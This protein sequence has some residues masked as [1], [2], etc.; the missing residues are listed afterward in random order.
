MEFEVLRQ[1]L[2][3]AMKMERCEWKQGVHVFKPLLEKVS[4]DL[5]DILQRDSF[6]NGLTSREGEKLEQL[7][8][9]YLLH[10]ERESCMNQLPID[11]WQDIVM[12]QFFLNDVK[13]PTPMKGFLFEKFSE[14]MNK[15][16]VIDMPETISSYLERHVLTNS[17]HSVLMVMVQKCLAFIAENSK[18]FQFE[19]RLD[20]LRPRIE[21][22]K[23]T[24]NQVLWSEP[25]APIDVISVFTS[26]FSDA[27]T[28]DVKITIGDEHILYL[29]KCILS[30]FSPVLSILF[31]DSFADTTSQDKAQFDLF[32]FIAADEGFS[33]DSKQRY[34]MIMLQSFYAIFQP[35]EELSM[36]E[37]MELFSICRVF[38]VTC[39]DRYVHQLMSK[40]MTI[41]NVDLV[42]AHVNA[43]QDEEGLDMLRNRLIVFSLQNGIPMKTLEYHV[44]SAWCTNVKH[45]ADFE[46]D[47][48]DCAYFIK[49]NLPYQEDE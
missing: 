27:S 30:A 31:S 39:L 1:V 6:M 32:T 47:F 7:I 44:N 12:Y 35:I 13:H 29:H 46:Y 20:K 4:Q 24:F 45:Q 37:L 18:H 22:Q 28:G 38:Q 5:C 26:L 33:D 10:L 8:Y 40:K 16:T 11:D 19:K 41:E 48:F 14:E 36:N 2:E 3:H 21:N 15:D 42:M 49:Q 25:E 9:Y 17:S 34:L 43:L 23:K